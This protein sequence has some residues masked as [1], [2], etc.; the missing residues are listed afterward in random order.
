MCEAAAGE[1]AWGLLPLPPPVCPVSHISQLA[2]LRVHPLMQSERFHL[3]PVMATTPAWLCEEVG[4]WTGSSRC[5]LSMGPAAPPGHH[6]CSWVCWAS[7]DLLLLES[8]PALPSI[9]KA[10]SQ[11][12]ITPFASPSSCGLCLPANPEKYDCSVGIVLEAKAEADVQIQLSGEA[13]PER[14][15]GCSPQRCPPSLA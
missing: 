3:E 7:G 11:P 8:A 4:V 15:V 5:G 2:S 14:A 9:P 6:G 12:V 13:R 10:T 1:Q